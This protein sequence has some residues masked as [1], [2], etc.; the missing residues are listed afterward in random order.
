MADGER[1]PGPRDVHDPAGFIARLQALKD[2]SGLTY[3]ELSARAEAVGE[4][5]PRSTVANMLSRT[6]LP[7]EELL[8]AFV[9]ACGA[10][11]D[12]AERW[13]AAR[14]HLAA[15]RGTH[16]GAPGDGA[17]AEPD[18]WADRD[19]RPGPD[20]R[21]A[22][23]HTAAPDGPARDDRAEDQEAEDQEAA[24]YQRAG[25]Q[26]GDPRPVDPTPA[27][28]TPADRLT[29]ERRVRD[30][31]E[32]AGRALVPVVG[33]VAL[34]VA[35]TTVASYVGDDEDRHPSA[36]APPAAGSVDIRA[37]HSGLCLN[38]RRGQR[39]G[40]V[41]QVDCAGAVVPR[42]SLAR[43]DGGLWRIAS[44][45]PDYGPGCSGIP[46]ETAREDGAPLVDQECGKRGAREA[47]L[48]EPL[49][50]D[51]ARGHRLRNAATG[52]CLTVPGASR[53][54]WTPVVHKP[55]APDG[56]GQLFAF[57]HRPADR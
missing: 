46:A 4:S 39:S 18:A 21:A 48:I 38:E 24:D 25:H 10:G 49:N 51:P 31:R 34:V 47:F 20:G 41:Y 33:G 54:Q 5:L 3:R 22:P 30:V 13:L 44:D 7:R 53:A 56:T 29:R 37:V 42:Y 36:A 28:P 43:L 57:P 26:A 9:R 6:T 8:V 35:V 52:L 32:W 16:D 55:C 12:E 14:K 17:P 19:A 45:H 40:Q 11:P 27:D 1:A 50:G 23:P 2:W 15:R